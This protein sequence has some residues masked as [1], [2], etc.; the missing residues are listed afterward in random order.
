MAHPRHCPLAEGGL[1][2]R[3][4]RELHGQPCGRRGGRGDLGRRTCAVRLAAARGAIVA[5]KRG[6]AVMAKS[7]QGR[8]NCKGTRSVWPGLRQQQ[9]SRCGI[10]VRNNR[11][12]ARTYACSTGRR[13]KA[14]SNGRTRSVR[15]SDV[16]VVK[17]GENRDR[18]AQGACCANGRARHRHA[19]G[20]VL[21]VELARVRQ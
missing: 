13:T 7:T 1:E 6:R 9:R 4:H 15:F 11:T 19:N 5:T 16:H 8:E 3:A 17:E 18:R 20:T 10:S 21:G 14:S 2:M 12:Y